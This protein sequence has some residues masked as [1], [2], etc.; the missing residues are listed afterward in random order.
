MSKINMNSSGVHKVISSVETRYEDD[1]AESYIQYIDACG[2]L[3]TKYKRDIEFIEKMY[4]KLRIEKVQFF[5]VD[6][7]KVKGALAEAGIP[8]EQIFEWI[9]EIKKNFENSFRASETIL[10]KFSVDS[11]EQMKGKIEEILNG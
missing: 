10:N 7:P 6:I 4:E 8:Q 2:Q 3:L 5:E 11:I 9:E 1:R